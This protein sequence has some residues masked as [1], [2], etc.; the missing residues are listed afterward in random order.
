MRIG[1]G[2]KGGAERTIAVDQEAA[3]KYIAASIAAPSVSKFLTVSASIARHNPAPY[4]NEDDIA[5][6]KGGWKAIPTY[7]EAK[8]KADE[9]LYDESRKLE[10]NGGK[11]V[12]WEDIHLR[13][14]MLSDK[15]A[16][17]KVDLGRA[18][19]RGEVTRNDVADV[20]VRL[21]QK[22]GAKGLW[23][24]LVNGEELAQEAVDRVVRDKVTSRT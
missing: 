4:W 14:G 23:I 9:F 24:D 3:K 16:T 20:A 11:K 10:N 19:A 13:P 22:G 21:L 15:P 8:L 2:G 6:F 18:R 5:T 17:G 7:C 1:A 12:G